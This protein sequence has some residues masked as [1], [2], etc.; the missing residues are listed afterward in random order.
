MKK[1]TAILLA[2]MMM[3]AATAAFAEEAAETPAP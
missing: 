2:I 3:L 1:I